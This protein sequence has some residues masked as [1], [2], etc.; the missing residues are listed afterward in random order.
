QN[1]GQDSS[2]NPIVLHISVLKVEEIGRSGLTTQNELTMGLAFYIDTM[3]LVEYTGGGTAKSA[4]DASKLIEELIRGNI[5]SM[6]HQFD[7][8]TN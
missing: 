8:R 6:L 4:G 3:K 5:A 2:T 1:A 7:K